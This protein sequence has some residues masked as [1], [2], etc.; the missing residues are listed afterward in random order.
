MRLWIILRWFLLTAIVESLYIIAL[1]TETTI[2]KVAVIGTTGRLGRET[3]QQLSEKGIGTRCLLRHNPTSATTIT[4]SVPHHPSSDKDE[5]ILY[6]KSLPGVELISGD[7]NDR[8]SLVKLV[9]GTTACL[10]L[11]GPSVPKPFFRSLIPLWFPETSLQHPKQINYIG[12]QN[13]LSV[14]TESSTCK[15]LVRITGKGETPWSIFSILINVFGGIAKGW[16]YEGEQLIRSQTAIKYTI[17]RPG[18]MK[19]SISD[20]ENK[21]NSSSANTSNIV[22]GLRDNGN[23]MKVSVVSYSQ[24]ANLTIQVLS[25][26]SCQRTTLTAMNIDTTVTPS[27][28]YQSIDEV[29]PDT[30][31]FPISLI[32]EHKKAAR[33]GGA[34][35]LLLGFFI[36][37]AIAALVLKVLAF[38]VNGFNSKL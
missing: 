22:L 10:A 31:E 34:T 33:F 15:H 4:T 20:D 9:E 24:I 6:L 17:I 11:H 14:M 19:E 8:Q 21:G 12:I 36:V 37:N 38:A 27:T 16:N 3:I 32:D 30:R 25:R 23:D 28:E 2:T 13:L 35:I 5:I 7:I 26:R 29:Q 18:I 1:S